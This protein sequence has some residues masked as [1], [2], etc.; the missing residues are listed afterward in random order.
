MHLR[1]F[2]CEF[3][4][5]YANI[6]LENMQIASRLIFAGISRCETEQ[7]KHANS[8]HVCMHNLCIIIAVHTPVNNCFYP[9]TFR[10]VMTSKSSM[11]L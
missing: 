8:V 7:I 10:E 9:K 11:M 3:H 2:I 4:V 5:R 6:E 1:I